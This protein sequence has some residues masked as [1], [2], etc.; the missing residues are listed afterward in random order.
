MQILNTAL[1]K[2]ILE[3]K[4][5]SEKALETL[6]HT[7]DT[8]GESLEDVITERGAIPHDKLKP[9]VANLYRVKPIEL[10]DRIIPD[11][12]L[13]IIPYALASRKYVLP[14]E[15]ST[16]EL[17]LAMNNPFNYELIN[18]LEK[19]KLGLFRKTGFLPWVCQHSNNVNFSVDYL[20]CQNL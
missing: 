2:A 17:Y 19:K 13:R 6:V 4:L 7:A 18:F 11:T 9:V 16:S 20:L 3:N 5:L 15:S 8:K 10:G 1:Q 14:F 12:L